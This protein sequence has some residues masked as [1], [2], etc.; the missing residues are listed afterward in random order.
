M[1]RL[2]YVKSHRAA[3]ISCV[4]GEAHHNR[5]GTP[6]N[7]ACDPRNLSVTYIKSTRTWALLSL[8]AALAFVTVVAYLVF[9]APGN[10]GFRTIFESLRTA[11]QVG[12]VGAICALVVFLFS[13][14]G[15][16]TDARLMSAIATV[17]F[18]VPVITMVLNQAA[19][20]PGDFIND[21]TTDLNDPPAF[22]A[23]IPLR[24]A[25]SNPIEYGGAAVAE[26]QRQVHPEVEPIISPLSKA[27][28]F[29]RA[30]ESAESLGWE[31]IAGDP[32]TG[33]IE[34]IATTRFFRFKDDVVIRV[35]E[36][37][38]GSRIDL[39]SRSRIGLSDLGKNAARIMQFV[40]EF[41]RG[42]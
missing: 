9:G 19:P 34:A 31:V 21:V 24:E 32:G 8:V 5:W 11:G 22:R 30:F 15:N 41:G 7:S 2:Y 23:V 20:P 29:Q 39:R 38:M 6:C 36:T 3:K 12:A 17:L 4:G 1:P 10:L 33:I 26:V 18:A 13:L 35:R 25:N 16:K 14:R 27:D 42:S 28:A 37:A 40:D